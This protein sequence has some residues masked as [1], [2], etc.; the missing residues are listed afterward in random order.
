MKRYDDPS[1][2]GS[3]VAGILGAVLLFV[4]IV[5]LQTMFYSMEQS[6]L[7]RKVYSRPSDELARLNAEQLEIINS[8]G[9][10]DEQGGVA[11]IPI[12]QAMELVAGESRP[13]R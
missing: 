4:I 13:R 1:F 11:H 9:W 5:V 8:Y 3:V 2:S 7:E 12:E 6:E 10:I